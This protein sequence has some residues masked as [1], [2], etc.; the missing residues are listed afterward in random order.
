MS[1][2][3][4]SVLVLTRKWIEYANGDVSVAQTVLRSA[5]SQPWAVA[6]HAQQAAEKIIKAY[7][8]WRQV[9]FPFTHSMLAELCAEPLCSHSDLAAGRR[10]TRYAVVGRYPGERP[11]HLEAAKS[12]ELAQSIIRAVM[13]QFDTEGAR[14]TQP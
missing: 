1:E 7:L 12:L 11:S 13:H 3:G 5:D 10:L 6:F 8:V 2:P 9:N 14:V 4:D